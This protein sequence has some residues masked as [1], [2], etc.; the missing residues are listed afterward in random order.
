M[1]R[2]SSHP[3]L[4]PTY[5]GRDTGTSPYTQE[6]VGSLLQRQVVSAIDGGM[7]RSKK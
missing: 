2:T 3:H 7:V 1:A 4:L 5:A 6:G